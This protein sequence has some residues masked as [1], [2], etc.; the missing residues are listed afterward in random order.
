MCGCVDVWM[1][2][3]VCGCVDVSLILVA[4]GNGHP[5]ECTKLFTPT[6]TLVPWNGVIICQ[7]NHKKIMI[8]NVNQALAETVSQPPLGP[9]SKVKDI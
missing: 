7:P 8:E 4:C 5:Q 2:G 1:C 9:R 6:L 3:C